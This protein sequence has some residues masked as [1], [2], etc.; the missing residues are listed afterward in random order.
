MPFNKVGD[1]VDFGSK[2][3]FNINTTTAKGL[4]KAIGLVGRFT[5]NAQTA[6]NEILYGKWQLQNEEG[7]G[8]AKILDRGLLDAVTKLSSVDYC[9]LFTS[10]LDSVQ[11]PQFKFDPKKEPENPTPFEKKLWVIQK[12]AYDYQQKID[13]F[14]SVYGTLTGSLSS[15]GL[16]E[17]V[18]ELNAAFDQLTGPNGLGDP[19]LIKSFPE[20]TLATNY[21]QNAQRK[22]RRYADVK[23][24]PVDEVQDIL[25]FVD[26]T[27]QFLVVIQTLNNPQILL[28]FA[29]RIGGDIV[30]EIA[31]KFDGGLKPEKFTNAIEELLKRSQ[32]VVDVANKMRGYINSTKN[33]VKLLLLLVKVFTLLIAAIDF[34]AQVIPSIFTTNA[35]PV[36]FSTVKQKYLDN[37]GLQKFIKRLG[38]IN[39]TL[40]LIS[41]FVSTLVFAMNDIIR[42]FNVILVNLQSCSR[43]PDDLI[44]NISSTIKNLEESKAPLEQFLE[45]IN[46]ANKAGNLVFGKYTISIVQEEVTD[47]G[48]AL[49]RRY[50]V[51]T[52]NDGKIAATST[53]TFASLDQIIINEVKIQ[54]VSKGLV[55][56]SLSVLSPQDL[57]TVLE[58]SKFLGEEANEI[59]FNVSIAAPDTDNPDLKEF[60]DNLPGGRA[61]RIKTR[62]KL[63]KENQ[64]IAGELKKADPNGKYN[65]KIIQQKESENIKLQIQN[66]EDERK[67]LQIKLVAAAAIPGAQ[68][69]LIPIIKRIKEIDAEL[70]KL[71]T[72]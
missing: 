3:A 26:G 2:G 44:N 67:G 53:P 42:K 28:A 20:T 14:Y 60:T 58:A 54:L 61:L 68:L 11:L 43:K 10:L 72:G 57:L 38:Q 59:D 29:N 55:E 37:E 48:I 15:V 17:L 50:G 40:G 18:L 33:I 16:R 23:I 52:G 51:A 32:K 46:K 31:D 62:R 65:S 8:I 30:K 35:E 41:T 9:K 36:R 24:I 56:Q 34:I 71:K 39:A 49:R 45:D 12:K 7:R 22:L 1:E 6:T 25:K 64:R 27:R 5:I 47:E 21:L 66:L 4:E 63:I 19:E 69:A 70:Q 13:K